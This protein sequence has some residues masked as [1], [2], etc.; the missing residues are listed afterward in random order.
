MSI[1]REIQEQ[2]S[3]K[4][5]EESEIQYRYFPS[6]C[7]LRTVSLLLQSVFSASRSLAIY[8]SAQD[9]CVHINSVPEI[10]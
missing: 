7:A 4:Y 5:R 6:D 9:W 8:S 10:S 1:Q 3:C 2:V